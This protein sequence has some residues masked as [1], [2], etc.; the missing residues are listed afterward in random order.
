MRRLLTLLLCIPL[1]V[2][3]VPA[4][5]AAD[6]GITLTAY[7]DPFDLNSEAIYNYLAAA[8]TY[9]TNDYSYT[10]AGSP[11]YVALQ[12]LPTVELTWTYAN[13]SSIQSAE[14][15]YGLSKDMKNAVV[16]SVAKR[17]KAKLSNLQTGATYYW[18]V[19]AKTTDGK[20]LESAVGTFKTKEGVRVIN[21]RGYNNCRDVGGWVTLDGKTVKQGLVY[22]TAAF[23]DLPD[24]NV[25]KL[26]SQLGIRTQL[27][28]RNESEIRAGHDGEYS[29]IS[30]LGKDVNYIHLW[31]GSYSGLFASDYVKQ[32]GNIMRVFADP[33]NYPIIFHCA[34][35][36]DRTGS[37]AI[38]LKALLGVSEND[39]V[40]DY[41]LTMD[42]YR[43]GAEPYTCTSMMAAFKKQ[44]GDT[45]Q[46]KAWLYY[47]DQCG[48]NAMELSN[49][50]NMMMTDSAVFKKASL[51]LPG[52]EQNGKFTL[53]LDLRKSGS[54]KAVTIEGDAV[55][56]SLN[57]ADG[58]L[59]V[60]AP[61]KGDGLLTGTITLD[62]KSTLDFE[63]D[64]TEATV[65]PAAST[66]KSAAS[67]TKS[68]TVATTAT[69]DT[70]A[71]TATP[72]TSAPVEESVDAPELSQPEDATDDVSAEESEATGDTAPESA[73]QAPT[74]SDAETDTDPKDDGTE[75]K[76]GI[77]PVVWIAVGVIA[78]VA[79]AVVVL[80]V[81][82]KRHG[83]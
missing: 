15:Y 72:D 74:T 22:R 48:L 79:V 42:R 50:Y 65:K 33:D 44:P 18:K 82:K 12:S 52:A 2:V 37:L 55:A 61:A 78:L 67:T 70:S 30:D 57:K 41:E 23:D 47:H 43:N 56:F 9:D 32:S 71:T 46:E 76:G 75:D 54:V 49:V 80:I 11:L 39:L 64:V 8:K 81:L 45:L 68:D 29:G 19:V 20:T 28:L 1:C 34:G 66:T 62:D 6:V 26:Q 77:S 73:E 31:A 51:T 63:V 3:A 60:T 36:A 17:T 10:K 53:S 59:T 5:H 4:V 40:A 21:M 58:T 69:P 35:G 16:E 13:A 24:A 27:D 83:V 7:P 25:K 38:M 14:L